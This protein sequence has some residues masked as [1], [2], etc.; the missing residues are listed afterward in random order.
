MCPR[1]RAWAWR[2]GRGQAQSPEEDSAPTRAVPALRRPQNRTACLT[3]LLPA[4]PLASRGPGTEGGQPRRGPRPGVLPTASC[5]SALPQPNDRA[6]SFLHQL[7]ELFLKTPFV[8]KE[9]Q[10]R[11]KFRTRPGDP[12]A[13]E[14]SERL[15]HRIEARPQTRDTGGALGHAAHRC[16]LLCTLHS[17]GRTGPSAQNCPSPDNR[18]GSNGLLRGCQTL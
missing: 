3:T 17:R 12:G 10:P 14:P 2:R 16:A 18:Y 7:G 11:V 9:L 1:T 13:Q 8:V 6:A 5:C 4:A 15:F